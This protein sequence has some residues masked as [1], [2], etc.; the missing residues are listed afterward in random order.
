MYLPTPPAVRLAAVGDSSSSWQA[1]VLI[2][3]AGLIAAG[4]WWDYQHKQKV[5]RFA[6]SRRLTYVGRDDRWVRIDTG[7]PYSQGRAHR[8]RHVMSGSHRGRP[9]V[10][11]E[12]EWKT[13][14]G[15]NTRT[16]RARKT[17]MGL[18]KEFPKLELSHEGFFGRV[19]RRMGMKDIELESGAFNERYRVAGD[20]RFAYDVLHPRFMQW[21]LG[22]D[23]PGFTIHGRYIAL[24]R[25]GRIDIDQ[26][27]R[28]IGYLD[29]IVEQLPG[30][31]VG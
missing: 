21:M 18:P 12:H 6:A 25:D 14:S 5:Q 2:A 13:G 1:I 10:I 29:A 8:T 3:F 30:Y 15:K 19:A 17:L 7:Y 9:I 11:Y 24:C 22:A 27:D 26:I 20:R 31:V 16:H 28:D 23:A 4:M